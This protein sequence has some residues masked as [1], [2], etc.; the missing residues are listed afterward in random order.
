MH[1]SAPHG[2]EG[3]PSPAP[4]RQDA[5]WSLLEGNRD[6]PGAGHDLLEGRVHTHHGARQGT[7][8]DG[9]NVDSDEDGDPGVWK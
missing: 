1:A 4:W 5:V 9:D 8:I 6:D 2:T 3:A 7:M